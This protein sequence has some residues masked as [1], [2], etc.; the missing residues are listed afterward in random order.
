MLR[1]IS[2]KALRIEALGRLSR[3]PAISP[4]HSNIESRITIVASIRMNL[5]NQTYAQF[6]PK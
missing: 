5:A 1:H 6:I 2:P 3:T 4:F